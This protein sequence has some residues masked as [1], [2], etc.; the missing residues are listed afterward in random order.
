MELCAQV[1]HNLR[2]HRLAAGLS[3][4]ELAARAKVRQSYLSEV[5]RGR[6]NPTILLL[7]DLAGVLGV[8]V[9]E[10]FDE[11]KDD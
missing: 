1:G 11:I 9:G 3:Q 4:E 7:Q 6:R 8:R 2:R 10:L 5:E